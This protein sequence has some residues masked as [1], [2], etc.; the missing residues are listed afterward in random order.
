MAAVYRHIDK[1]SVRDEIVDFICPSKHYAWNF[2]PSRTG[3]AGSIEFRRP[4]GVSTCKKATH[5]VAFTLSFVWM[6][7]RFESEYYIQQFDKTELPNNGNHP[8]F[9]R[10]LLK[11]A[12]QIGESVHLDPRLLQQDDPD[13]LHITNM[14]QEAFN[15]LKEQDCR[16]QWSTNS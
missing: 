4:P 5:W 14:S 12:D 2:R 3:R 8:D 10:L 16:Y 1:L 15:W 11:A 9:Q 7:M 6:A 13:K